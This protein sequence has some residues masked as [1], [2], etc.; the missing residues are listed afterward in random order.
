MTTKRNTPLQLFVLMLS[1]TVMLAFVPLP[2]DARPP[3]GGGGGGKGHVKR[4]GG[5]G[6]V[7]HNRN[8]NVNHNRNRNVNVNHGRNVNVNVDHRRGPRHPVAAGV[9]VGT[10]AAVTAAAIGSVVHSPPP[11]CTTVVRYDTSYRNCGGVWYQPQ[12]SGNN[13]TYIV[14]NEP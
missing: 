11:N 14:I 9:A 2:S 7:N 13:V 8:R 6:N 5:H 10:A 4:G 12:Y 1:V 3:R